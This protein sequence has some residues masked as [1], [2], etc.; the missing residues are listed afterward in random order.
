[1]PSSRNISTAKSLSPGRKTFLA[2]LVKAQTKL[3]LHKSKG[4][5]ATGAQIQKDEQPILPAPIL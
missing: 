2:A 4:Q 1:M 3:L 5:A